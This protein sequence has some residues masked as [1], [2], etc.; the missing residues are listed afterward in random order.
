M[1]TPLIFSIISLIFTAISVYLLFVNHKLQNRF[2]FEI[3]LVLFP[4]IL[5]YE[6]LKNNN[7]SDGHELSK[8]EELHLRV[9]IINSGK[10]IIPISYIS[11]EN[12]ISIVNFING[13]DNKNNL[14]EAGEFFK[15]YPLDNQIKQEISRC[16][17]LFLVDRAGRKHKIPKKTLSNLKNHLKMIQEQQSTNI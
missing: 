9:Q 3:K 13:N 17:K 14:K 6:Y 1:S 10:R 8:L 2:S 15:H 5:Y 11:S 12:N 7:M 4:K 16:K